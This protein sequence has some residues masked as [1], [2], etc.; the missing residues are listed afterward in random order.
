MNAPESRAMAQ[1]AQALLSAAREH[2][3]AEG[4]HRKAARKC[5]QDLAQLQTQFAALG[6]KLEMA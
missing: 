3:R 4:R 6:I 1:A 2:K 5:M